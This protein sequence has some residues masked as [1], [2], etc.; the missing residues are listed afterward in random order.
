MTHIRARLLGTRCRQG[1]DETGSQEQPASCTSVAISQRGNKQY[2]KKSISSFV[3]SR[4]ERCGLHDQSGIPDTT[5]PPSSSCRCAPIPEEEGK[6]TLSIS[7][8]RRASFLDLRYCHPWKR[9]GR[10]FSPAWARFVLRRI[11]PCSGVHQSLITVEPTRLINTFK[12]LFLE[13]V[14]LFHFGTFEFPARMDF[15]L[16]S[17]PIP[18]MLFVR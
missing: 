9:K 8:A 15:S 16:E 17:V 18:A 14:F 5:P 11:L 4:I 12:C 1:G 3:D 13:L 10:H 6:L 2:Q 7:P